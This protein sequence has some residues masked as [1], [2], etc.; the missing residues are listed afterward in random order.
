MC[1]SSPEEPRFWCMCLLNFVIHG[2]SFKYIMF[3]DV[4]VF[5]IAVC[6]EM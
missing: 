3:R 5:L 6:N 2:L 4:P 1:L